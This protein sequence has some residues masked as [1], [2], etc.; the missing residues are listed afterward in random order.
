MPLAPALQTLA[1]VFRTDD[2]ALITGGSDTGVW[3][4][5]EP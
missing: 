5:E 3:H 1:G 4:I 2:Q